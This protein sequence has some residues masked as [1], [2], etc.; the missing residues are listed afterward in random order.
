MTRQAR[1]LAQRQ[2]AQAAVLP[3]RSWAPEIAG[4][5]LLTLA[6]MSSAGLL[7]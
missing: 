3:Q 2:R 5:C 1:N 7:A 4:V 6:V